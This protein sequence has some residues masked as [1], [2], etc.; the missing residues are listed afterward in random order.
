M[1][2][3]GLNVIKIRC[4]ARIRLTAN[5][6]TQASMLAL[7]CIAV[8][9]LIPQ[10]VALSKD[11]PQVD[12]EFERQSSLVWRSRPSQEEEGLVKCLYQACVRHTESGCPRKYAINGGV[13]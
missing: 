11:D 3:G 4:D 9:L 2:G 1:W 12:S 7:I 8:I 13:A 6:E 5:P 10:C